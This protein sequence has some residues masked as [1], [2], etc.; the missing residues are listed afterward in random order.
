MRRSLI[1]FLLSLAVT[2][3]AALAGADPRDVL[4]TLDGQPITEAQADEIAGQIMGKARAAWYEARRAATDEVIARL[5]VEREAKRRGVTV[6]QLLDAEVVSKVPRISDAEIKEFYEKNRGRIQGALE[7]VA[8]QIERYLK[9]QH[10]SLESNRLIT[11]LRLGSK[12]AY[13]ISPP[14]V[15]VAAI[16]PAKG[17]PTAPVTIVE[18]SDFECFFCR[19]AVPMLQTLLE[20]Y[21]NSVRIVFRDFP[22]DSHPAARVAAEA[23]RCANDQGKFWEYHD[24]LFANQGKFAVDAL[25]GYAQQLSLDGGQ[26]AACL[27]SGKHKEAVQRD[28]EDGRRAAVQGTPTFFIN[29]R[30]VV[31]AQPIESFRAVIDDEL[32]RVQHADKK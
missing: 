4:A 21:G 24:L 14:K 23:A 32:A 12:I 8:P 31:G 16:G 7:D 20:S 22:M 25:K 6:D 19:R 30:A 3:P 17:S 27:S 10:A 2:A 18:F 28:V 15:D 5:L 13:M 29:G 26:F 1:A 11:Q 9:Q